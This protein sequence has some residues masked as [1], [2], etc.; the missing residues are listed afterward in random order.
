MELWVIM[1][2][3]RDGN[4]LCSNQAAIHCMAVAHAATHSCHHL[5]SDIKIHLY[6]WQFLE[7]F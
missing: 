3:Q 7:I 4:L 1:V 2:G 6:T 5:K